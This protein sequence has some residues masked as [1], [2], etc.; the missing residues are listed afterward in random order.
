MPPAIDVSGIVS[1]LKIGLDDAE[2]D[3]T[4]ELA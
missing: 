2:F 3:S 1:D 4:W